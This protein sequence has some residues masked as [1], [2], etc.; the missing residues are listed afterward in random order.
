[1]NENEQVKSAQIQK[2][3]SKYLLITIGKSR[4]ETLEHFKHN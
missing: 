4:E 1:L 2:L 3:V